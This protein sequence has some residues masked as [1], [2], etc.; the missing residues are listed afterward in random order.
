MLV[1]N[2]PLVRIATLR[3]YLQSQESALQA[4]TRHPRRPNAQF[5]LREPFLRV[6]HQKFAQ[7]AQLGLIK[8]T[9]EQHIALIARWE[10]M[11]TF[12]V[13]LIAQSVLWENT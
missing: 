7:T 6:L 10:L 3:N 8:A 13:Q 4:L 2:A 1:R 5:V 12:R 9:E 11:L